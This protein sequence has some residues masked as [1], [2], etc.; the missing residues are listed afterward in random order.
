MPATV[1]RAGSATARRRAPG[2]DRGVQKREDP[3]RRDGGRLHDGELR[4]GVTDGQ[5]EALRVLHERHQDPEGQRAVEDLEAAPPEEGR[6]HDGAERLG[7]GVERRLQPDAAEL[8]LPVALA[9][10]TELPAPRRLAPEEL[11]DRHARDR[12]LELRVQ[13]RQAGPHVPVGAPDRPPE[14]HGDHDE[15]G[16]HGEGD[17]REAEMQERASRR[18]PRRA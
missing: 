1:V 12:F 14:G 7:D 3:L 5:V 2:L 15:Q 11:D 9:Q 4:R 8:R 13:V 16:Q 18:P 10:L 6:H 17:Q